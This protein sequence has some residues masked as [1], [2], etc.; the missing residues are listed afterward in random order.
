MKIMKKIL[1]SL[2]VLITLLTITSFSETAYAASIPK[3]AKHH[4]GHYYYVYDDALSWSDAKEKC[5]KRGG[6][7]ATITSEKEN[8][9]VYN[10]I[11]SKGYDSAY[12]GLYRSGSSWKWVTGEKFKYSNW[13]SGEPGSSEKYGMYYY[14]YNQGQWNDGHWNDNSQAYI[15]E[16][17]YSLKLS[18]SSIALN[19][20]SSQTI[21]YTV[22][23]DTSALS[24]KMP[25]WTSGNTNVAKV[26][27]KGK[28][29]AIGSGSCKI[30][31]KFGT[32]KKTVKVVV[33]PEQVTNFSVSKKS[34]NSITLKWKKQSNVSGYRIYMYDSDIKEYV[35]V[36][37]IDGDFKTATIKKLKKGKKYKFKIRAFVKDGNKI[38][39]G[40]YSS[41]L[42]AK[43][44]G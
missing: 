11:I 40:K 21:E 18:E 5:K 24:S 14:K 44:K 28:I 8:T 39:Y 2:L 19:I 3:G 29:V 10:Y 41:V 23:G 34:K 36:K 1:S 31:C 16:W 7:L 20:G 13:A 26:S 6:H 38:Y 12:F 35:K 27:S 17:D 15:C 37:T 43:T 33:Y 25:K 4:N 9:F 32:E 42:T 30:T 22:K